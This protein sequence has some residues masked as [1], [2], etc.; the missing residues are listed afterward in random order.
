LSFEPRGDGG[1]SVAFHEIARDAW[2]TLSDAA[3][4]WAVGV[5]DHPIWAWIGS[6]IA[7]TGRFVW[8]LAK[9]AYLTAAG[10]CER[11]AYACPL[12]ARIVAHLRHT[13]LSIRAQGLAA[14][15]KHAWVR[16]GIA[17]ALLLGLVLGVDGATGFDR[18][19]RPLYVLPIW[20]AT[21]IGGSVAGT[22][23]VLFISS[24]LGA[25]DGILG[26]GSGS[27]LTA[28]GILRTVSLL[29]VMLVIA[30]FEIRFREA[31]AMATYDTLT[32]VLN[33][34]SFEQHAAEAV[35]VAIARGER[36]AIGLA[37]CNRFKELNDTFGHA[38][39]DHALRVLSRRLQAVSRSNGIVGRF[40]GDEFV[41][42]FKGLNPEHVEEEMTRAKRTFARHIS[43]LGARGTISYGIA[44]LGPDGT[45]L[46]AL[47]RR[48][49]ER[50]YESKRVA[51]AVVEVAEE[52]DLVEEGAFHIGP[53]AS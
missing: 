39:G 40:G 2:V 20:I 21:R 23:S 37:D 51:L 30:R 5:T 42:V 25:L 3:T 38:F 9:S 11:S 46:D 35:A 18:G 43:S 34:A 8:G 15:R 24:V 28:E 48:A 29:V 49:D 41:V 10:I 45:T 16:T 53:L 31:R 6:A 36:L 32:G 27:I 22:L 7:R 14:Y 19:S 50:M 12:L 13:V 26:Y 47:L 4:N 33:R 44:V 17:S 52:I 1:K